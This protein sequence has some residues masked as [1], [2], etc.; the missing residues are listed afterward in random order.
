MRYPQLH[1][2]S[3][4]GK[5]T[6]GGHAST[7]SQS[8]PGVSTHVRGP[9]T[10][11]DYIGGYELGSF[12]ASNEHYLMK[13]RDAAIKDCVVQLVRRAVTNPRLDADVDSLTATVSVVLECVSAYGPGE[14]DLK[15]LTA[16]EVQCEHLAATL[17]ATSTWRTQV[18]G[19][20]EA[21]NIAASAS[22]I[23]GLEPN[24]VLFGLL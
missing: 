24:D 19:W 10:N 1:D 17:R 20:D 3:T 12:Y 18:P 5:I 8:V 11:N 7:Y 15:G 2:N 22:R 9:A 21:L 16:D 13:L 4:V 14:V 23:H 6:L